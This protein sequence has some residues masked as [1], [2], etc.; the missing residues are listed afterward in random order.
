M[1]TKTLA[2]LITGTVI[3]AGAAIAIATP[4]SLK[5]SFMKNSL[6]D[7]ILTTQPEATNISPSDITSSP[8]AEPANGSFTT[9]DAQQTSSSSI[10]PIT[11][12]VQGV[13]PSDGNTANA[14]KRKAFVDAVMKEYSLVKQNDA[15]GSAGPQA[16]AAKTSGGIDEADPQRHTLRQGW[17]RLSEYFKLAYGSSG[18]GKYDE[19][20]VKYL[21]RS[22]DT[23]QLQSWC[24]IFALWALKSNGLATDANWRNGIGFEGLLGKGIRKIPRSQVKEGD[25]GVLP[26]SLVHHFIVSKVDESGK[27]VE[28][29]NGNGTNAGVSLGNGEK[30]NSAILFYTAF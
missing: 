18:P 21:P 24:G 3:T 14:E 6:W 29:I 19:D 30:A 17:E 28:T 1:K 20:I 13:T 7:D 12:D 8:T 9:P 15:Q 10:P 22:G 4:A 2:L 25:I 16:I 11:A 5:P 26:G 23:D 27:I